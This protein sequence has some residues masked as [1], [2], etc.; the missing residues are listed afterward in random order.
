M[1]K[2]R[3]CGTRYE[4]TRPLQTACGLAC[5]I[6]QNNQAKLKKEAKEDK[7]KREKLKSR[8]QWLKEAQVVF[9]RYIRARDAE[10]TCICC[11]R[12][13]GNEAWVPGG[14]WDAGHYLSV[15]SHP[16]LR[17]NENNCHKQLKLCNAGAG[18]YAG[19]NHTVSQAYRIRLI[20]KIGLAAVEELEG[21][22][23]PKKYNIDELRAIKAE[24]AQ[25]TKQL[26]VEA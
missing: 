13:G 10:Q 8:A 4:P 23:A 15:G 24:Y 9:N 5:A 6:I 3:T 18:K 26:Q 20:E 14:V 1:R 25:K 19:K 7:A 16:E 2:C 17:F 12:T 11:G 21:P 22:H